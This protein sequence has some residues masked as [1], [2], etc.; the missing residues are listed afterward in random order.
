[1]LFCACCGHRYNTAAAPVCQF[2]GG[3]HTILLFRTVQELRLAK[4]RK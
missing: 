2:Q 1:M 4:E 3:V